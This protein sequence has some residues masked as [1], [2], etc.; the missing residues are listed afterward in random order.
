[1]A[2]LGQPP[3][4]PPGGLVITAEAVTNLNNDKTFLDFGD[5]QVAYHTI[6]LASSADNPAVQKPTQG[7]IEDYLTRFLAHVSRPVP[8]A[9]GTAASSRRNRM[10]R[11][12]MAART[13]R[14]YQN[15]RWDL[16][17]AIALG[18]NDITPPGNAA[19]NV[20]LPV[21]P[22]ANI[23][24]PMPHP[25]IT[26]HINA[27]QQALIPTQTMYD[28]TVVPLIPTNNE[29]RF[30]RET[31]RSALRRYYDEIDHPLYG[32]FEAVDGIGVP[33]RFIAQGWPKDGNS[34]WAS[35]H[36]TRLLQITAANNLPGQL[37]FYLNDVK[38]PIWQYFNYVLHHPSHPRHR[39]YV[40]LEQHSRNEIE[41]RQ[42]GSTIIWGEMGILR[43]LHLNKPDSG[44]PMYGHFRGMLQ[45][46]ADFYEKEVV[47]FIRPTA[48]LAGTFPNQNPYIVEV[49]GQSLH[50]QTNGQIF[51]VTDEA[52][53]EQYQ[54]VTHF[55]GIKLKYDGTD[56]NFSTLNRNNNDRWGWIPA[57]WYVAVN[58]TPAP[59]N[60]VTPHTNALFAP[61][62]GSRPWLHFLG[63]E[64]A[65]AED[66]GYREGRYPLLPDLATVQ[67]GSEVTPLA[68]VANFP[69]PFAGYSIASGVYTFQGAEYWPQWSNIKLYEAHTIRKEFQEARRLNIDVHP[70]SQ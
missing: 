21:V 46:I 41:T 26:G 50:G 68:Q 15:N 27:H 48:A 58:P 54:V 18:I 13:L 16:S 12:L 37:T 2:G 38:Y 20:N 34:L 43:A 10:D 5:A 23:P 63:G 69:W 55:G 36:Y 62:L 14:G 3:P 8:R 70:L 61:Q 47:L 17:G 65:V 22:W 32:G 30:Y 19:L 35:L 51:L 45:V 42:P 1:M 31:L 52:D 9:R 66:P 44:P 49:Y 11:V 4:P 60:I 57:P 39:L 33:V 53:R 40:V 24:P 67:W 25:A 28:K 6:G 29:A 56:P 7:Q 59:V 64:N